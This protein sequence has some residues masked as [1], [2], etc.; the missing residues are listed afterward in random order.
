MRCTWKNYGS[1]A[2]PVIE[3]LRFLKLYHLDLR[4]LLSVLLT[5]SP[6][7]AWSR[8]PQNI[9]L[10]S[11]Y[12]IPFTCFLP[13]VLSGSGNLSPV[14]L[15]LPS[16]LRAQA[17]KW[18]SLADWPLDMEH[19]RNAQVKFAVEHYATELPL[20]LPSRPAELE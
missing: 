15:W 11:V 17:P 2:P 8:H 16:H 1:S 20:P 13:C 6:M 12:C 10:T 9:L 18:G 7:G 4:T 3:L 14:F 5:I 19:E